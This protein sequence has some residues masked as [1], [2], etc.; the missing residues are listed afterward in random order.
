MFWKPERLQWKTT[1]L[2]FREQFTRM[3]ITTTTTTTSTTTIIIIIIMTTIDALGTVSKRLV[4]G[5]R[6]NR[7]RYYPNY[8]IVEIGQNTAK[9]PGDLNRLAGT[10]TPVKHHQLSLMWKN[11]KKQNNNN[12]NNTRTRTNY[13]H[14]SRYGQHDKR[15]N[16]NN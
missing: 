12:N 16:D 8:S 7:S 15:K 3:E 6:N 1:S 2:H 11:L 5:L 13:S 14:Q 9:S 10:Q 4:Q